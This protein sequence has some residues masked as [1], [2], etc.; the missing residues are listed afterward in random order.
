MW[1][2]QPQK[3][4]ELHPTETSYPMELVHMDFVTTGKVSEPKVL[5]VLV[6]TD[7]FTKYAQAFVTPKQTVQ[8][9]A[10]TLWEQ[11]PVHYGWPSQIMTDQGRSF[12]SSLFK[13]LCTLTQTKKIRTTHT[14]QNQMGHEKDL[15]PL[16]SI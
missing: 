14:G 1:F 9:V 7:H 5:N 12:E 8:A 10:K 13:E 15:M 2:K 4:E 16:S 11:Y 3:R 6:F